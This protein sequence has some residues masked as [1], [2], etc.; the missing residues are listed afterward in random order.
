MHRI[1]SCF[2][3]FLFAATLSAQSADWIWSARYVITEDAQHRVIP[4]GAVAIKDNRIVGVGT[5]AELTSLM[6]SRRAWSVSAVS[7]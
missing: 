5:E 4:N 7:S 1:S 6:S 3:F 2:S